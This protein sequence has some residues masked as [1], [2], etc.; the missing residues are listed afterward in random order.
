MEQHKNID[1]LL[2]QEKAF[3]HK[4]EV[5]CVAECCGIDA[6]NLAPD[7]V[8]KVAQEHGIAKVK[9]HLFN[10][11][12]ALIYWQVEFISSKTLNHYED[13]TDFMQTLLKLLKNLFPE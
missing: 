9:A 13:R 8:A 1:H 4:L 3:W 10:L 7:F 12:E 11:L 2:A 5:H 6:L